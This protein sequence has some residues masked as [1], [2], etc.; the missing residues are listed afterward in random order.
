MGNMLRS[1]GESLES[2]HCTEGQRNWKGNIG[3]EADGMEDKFRIPRCVS[4]CPVSP[5]GESI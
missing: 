2:V 1:P 5:T 3:T 4:S